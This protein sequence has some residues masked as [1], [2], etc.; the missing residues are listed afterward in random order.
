M[1]KFY[2]LSC[3][4]LVT[5]LTFGQAQKKRKGS[6]SNP[7]QSQKETFLDKQW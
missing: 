5:G 1:K 6:F 3:L 7:A 2:L 4:L